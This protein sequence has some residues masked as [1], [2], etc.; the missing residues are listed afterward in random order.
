MALTDWQEVQKQNKSLSIWV[1]KKNDPSARGSGVI[2]VEKIPLAKGYEYLFRTSGSMYKPKRF[3]TKQA[4][5]KHA[6]Q[7]MRDH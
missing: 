2:R 5:L 3:K 1:K 6:R 4:A 7:Y